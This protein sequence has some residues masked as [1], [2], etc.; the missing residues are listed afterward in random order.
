MNRHAIVTA[1]FGEEW[2]RIAA[3]TFPLME[4]YAARIG[5]SFVVL[6][7]RRWPEKHPHWEKFAMND[8]LV[9]SYD[10]LAWIDADAIVSPRAPSIFDVVP[11]DEFGAFDE[12]KIFT[13]RVEQLWL[14]APFYGVEHKCVERRPFNYFNGGVTVFG[15][16]HRRLYTLPHA[17]KPDSIMPEQTYLN[18]R[19]AELGMKFRDIGITWNGLHSIRGAGDRKDL[20][21]IHYAGWPRADARWV[22]DMKMQMI[23]D[24]GGW[25]R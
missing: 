7:G 11:D 19:L 13:D 20:H 12:G 16:K 4:Q 10:R 15:R 5:A 2:W 6:T 22:D 9:S 18:L 14:H 1:A 23:A 3:S 8:L 25:E 17:V 24:R 21:I